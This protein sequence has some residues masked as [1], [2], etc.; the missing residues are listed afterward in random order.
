MG[1]VSGR[2]GGRVTGKEKCVAERQKLISKQRGATQ[3]Q[4]CQ[5]WFRSKG[6]LTE[7]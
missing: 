1:F 6:G 5:C 7:M 3:Y 4:V 2:S